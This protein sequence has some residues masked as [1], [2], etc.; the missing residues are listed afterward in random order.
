MSGFDSM[1]EAFKDQ[2]KNI[3]AFETGMSSD[4]EMN[5]RLSK[6]D[7]F[8]IVS[9]SDSHSF[10]PWRLGRE[11]T[12]FDIKKLSYKEIIHAIRENKIE[13]T[14]ETSPSYGKYHFDGHRSCKFSC[15]PKEAAKLNNICPVC[16][17]PLTIGV[18][19]RVEK[20]ADRPGGFRPKNAKDFKS[21]LPLS[22]LIAVLRKWPLESKK[23]MA[24]YEKIVNA[25]SEFKILLET[26]SEDLSS[27]TDDKLAKLIMLNR[28][29]KIKVKP[30][31][32]GVYGVLEIEEQK[33]LF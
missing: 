27:I 5:W 7:K 21:I 18:L 25:S 26:S 8:S 31:Y 29:G 15:S 12:A 1:E 30:G 11:A 13:F 23:V 2:V 19:D 17:K 24:E 4:P 10:W 20:L 22:E 16:K 32:D 33:K 6:L 9:F 3:H 28:V 14:I